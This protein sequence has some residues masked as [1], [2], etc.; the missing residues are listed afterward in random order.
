[1]AI[2]LD[3]RCPICGKPLITR[4][5][6]DLLG[7][8][9]T[10]V[11]TKFPVRCPRCGRLYLGSV[12]DRYFGRMCPVCQARQETIE[13]VKRKISAMFEGLILYFAVK[14]KLRR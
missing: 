14:D 9:Y 4:E 7:Y 10:C 11:Q 2:V 8:C 3:E 13:H 6:R 12:W 1:M 5:E